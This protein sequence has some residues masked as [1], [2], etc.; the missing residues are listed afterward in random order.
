MFVFLLTKFKWV[1]NCT[2]SEKDVFVKPKPTKKKQKQRSIQ[3]YHLKIKCSFVVR[4]LHYFVQ[5]AFIYNRETQH[6]PLVLK[7]RTLTPGCLA[8]EHNTRCSSS[9]PFSEAIYVL[10]RQA[11]IERQ[12]NLSNFLPLSSIKWPNCLH[13]PLWKTSGQRLIRRLAELPW[14]LKSWI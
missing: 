10:G 6:Q 8:E 4:H 2:F 12:A 7:W 9:H 5:S 11:S 13:M 1:T 3:F 14:V